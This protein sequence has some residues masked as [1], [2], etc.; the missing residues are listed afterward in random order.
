MIKTETH[1][2]LCTG[3]T[4]F[5]AGQRGQKIFE[6]TNISPARIEERVVNVSSDFNE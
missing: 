1:N 3:F 2:G 6:K 4:I 5:V